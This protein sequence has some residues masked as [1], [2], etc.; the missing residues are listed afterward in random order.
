MASEPLKRPLWRPILIWTV[1]VEILTC[2]L[3][4]GAKL[5]STRDTASTIG[6]MTFGLRIHHSYIGAAI[7]LLAVFLLDRYPRLARCCL[8]AGAALI[9]SDLI[10][11]FAVLAYFVGD[12]Q[13]DLWY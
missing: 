2:V 10:H 8:I 3:R 6:R 4:F 7:A 5:E 12:P 1:L 9:F 11:H 13:F